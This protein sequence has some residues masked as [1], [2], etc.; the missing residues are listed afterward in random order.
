[1]KMEV[2]LVKP[3]FNMSFKPFIYQNHENIPVSEITSMYLSTRVN[4][5]ETVT[6]WTIPIFPSCFH[7]D[8]SFW[9]NDGAFKY[10]F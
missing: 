4:N 5:F 1:M 7:T 3:T 9:T 8:W 6:N 10:A 2:V